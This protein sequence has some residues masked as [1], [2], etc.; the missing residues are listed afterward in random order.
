MTSIGEQLG[1]FGALPRAP[2]KPKQAAQPESEDACSAR[3]VRAEL[4][5]VPCSHHGPGYVCEFCPAAYH[6]DGL[7]FVHPSEC[8]GRLALR[9]CARCL[10][11]RTAGRW[12][13]ATSFATLGVCLDCVPLQKKDR[14][15]A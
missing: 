11:M 12:N 6:T 2:A 8:A 3:V 14:S 10:E 1:L 4:A 15:P 7:G 5:A 13:H 9:R